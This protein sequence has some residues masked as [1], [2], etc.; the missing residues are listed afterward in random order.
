MKAERNGELYEKR[1]VF[2][3]PFSNSYVAHIAT[4][5]SA[6]L[7]LPTE[8]VFTKLTSSTIRCQGLW[9][10]LEAIKFPSLAPS[11]LVILEA[12]E[13]GPSSVQ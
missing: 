8:P 1:E 9:V 7:G 12:K 10:R 11:D 2:S 13:S 3:T 6:S 5:R 4:L